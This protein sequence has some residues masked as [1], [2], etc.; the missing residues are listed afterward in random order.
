MSANPLQPSL[1]E[2]FQATSALSGGNAS[3]IEAL[4]EDYLGDPSAVAPAW[5]SYFDSLKGRAAGD[6]PAA[7]VFVQ[8][9][10]RNA[11]GADLCV[12][13]EGRA[14]VLTGGQVG[15]LG[16]AVAALLVQHG[17]DVEDAVALVAL[18]HDVAL[19]CGAQHVEHVDRVEAPAFEIRLAL[20]NGQL[21]HARRRL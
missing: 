16:D 5:R 17:Y 7:Q 21:R 12:D 2:Q 13:G 15:D 11:R 3:F 8:R 19:V 18:P 6:V 1:L 10:Q 20:A 9:V 14:V 4:Y